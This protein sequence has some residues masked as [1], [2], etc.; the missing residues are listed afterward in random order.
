MNGY[1][2]LRRVLEGSLFFTLFAYLTCGQVLVLGNPSSAVP[3]TEQSENYLMVHSEF[4]LSYNRARG[5]PNWVTWHLSASDLG[6]IDRTNSFRADTK[7]P[8]SWRIKKGDYNGSGFHRGH[9]APSEDRSTTVAKN[10]QTFL[11]TNMQPQ[12]ARLNSGTWRSLEQYTQD[13]VRAGMEGYITAGCYGDNGK[14]TGTGKVT[15]PTRCWKV[16]LLLPEGPNDLRRI[17]PTTRVIAVDMPNDPEILSG[18]RNY[19]VTVDAIEEATGYDLFSTLDD[20]I[21]EVLERSLDSL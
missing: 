16:V 20:E 17:G 6:P 4:I 3:D 1:R 7:L 5:A 9:M 21:E 14:V 8:Q 18:W 13:Q 19:R 12:V 10:R 15:I 11:M 2:L